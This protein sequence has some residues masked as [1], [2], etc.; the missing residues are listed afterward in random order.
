MS[1][2]TLLFFDTETTGVNSKTSSLIEIGAIAFQNGVEVGKFEGTCQPNTEKEIHLGAL[3]VNRVKPTDFDELGD[4]F[5]LADNFANF[6]L[7]LPKAYNRSIIPCGHNVNFDIGFVS[8]FLKDNCLHGFED[9]VSYRS[10]DT[11][12][13][14]RFL[15]DA[16]LIPCERASLGTLAKVL[17]AGYDENKHHTALYDAELSAKVYFKMMEIVQG[18]Q[19]VNKVSKFGAV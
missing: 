1:N 6:L 11:A 17:D 9:F 18:K 5:T 12:S 14:G 2:E 15:I 7:D 8:E 16:R 4:P 13:I 3:A 19:Q 10:I